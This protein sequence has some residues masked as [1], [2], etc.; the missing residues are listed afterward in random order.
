M[1]TEV[2]NCSIEVAGTKKFDT[3]FSRK[4]AC[5]PHSDELMVAYKNKNQFAISSPSSPK[6]EL[7]DFETGYLQPAEYFGSLQRSNIPRT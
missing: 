6:I 1:V 5:S 7:F 4:D 3:S 2:E